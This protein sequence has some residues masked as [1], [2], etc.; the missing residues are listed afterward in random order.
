MNAVTTGEWTQS[1]VRA[2]RSGASGKIWVLALA[3]LGAGA[4]LGGYSFLS[5]QRPSTERPSATPLEVAPAAEQADEAR[6]ATERPVDEPPRTDVTPAGAASVPAS[7][8]AEE[9][10]PEQDEKV[11][12]ERPS[13]RTKK[14]P[15][16]RPPKAP[17]SPET[18][19]NPPQEPPKNEL[20]F[21][22]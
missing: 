9:A 8:D 6:D 2:M 17:H 22:Y 15:P 11:D 16:A 19:A 1:D 12:E 5:Q 4:L 10:P 21:G 20:D 18:P 3:F 7:A 14:R 13:R